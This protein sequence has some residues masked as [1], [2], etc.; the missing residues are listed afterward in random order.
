METFLVGGLKGR[1]GARWITEKNVALN[2][3]Q[4][5]IIIIIIVKKV[6]DMI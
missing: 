1:G 6:N 2:K 3:N 4:N 5:I